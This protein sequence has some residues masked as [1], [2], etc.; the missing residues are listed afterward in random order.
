MYEH[1]LGV[2][3]DLLEAERMYISAL[4]PE[5]GAWLPTQL[6]IAKLRVKKKWLLFRESM[7]GAARKI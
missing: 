2:T 3:Q 4:A 1:G 5:K 6:A 7:F